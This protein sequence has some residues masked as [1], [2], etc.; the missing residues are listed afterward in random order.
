VPRLDDKN[1]YISTFSFSGAR[2]TRMTEE[3]PNAVVLFLISKF[4]L[5]SIS[6]AIVILIGGV[7]FSIIQGAWSPFQ[8]SGSLLVCLAASLYFLDKKLIFENLYMPAIEERINN[9]KPYW[10]G[11]DINEMKKTNRDMYISFYRGLLESRIRKTEIFIVLLGTFVWGFGDM[12]PLSI[13][14]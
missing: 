4:E 11:V 14:E 10:P 6:L 13:G 8:R 9:I 12:I 3:K 2:I 5:V 1:G 7:L